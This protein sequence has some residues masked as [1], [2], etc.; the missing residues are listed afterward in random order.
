VSLFTN[1]FLDCA[2]IK[3][4]ILHQIQNQF[5]W[6]E[7]GEDYEEVK[8]EVE[9]KERTKS[10]LEEQKQSLKNFYENIFYQKEIQRSERYASDNQ[11]LRDTLTTTEEENY[12][13]KKRIR[14]LEAKIEDKDHWLDLAFQREGFLVQENKEFKKDK[15][16]LLPN[17]ANKYDTN[18]IYDIIQRIEFHKKI[19]VITGESS[20]SDESEIF[21]F[22]LNKGK[23]KNLIRLLQNIKIP[24]LKGLYFFKIPSWIHPKVINN[25]LSSLNYNLAQLNLNLP[26]SAKEEHSLGLLEEIF[27]ISHKIRERLQ[28]CYFMITEQLFTKIITNFQHCNE[29]KFYKCSIRMKWIEDLK[30][31]EKECNL[32]N[33]LFQRFDDKAVD[34]YG[35]TIKSFDNICKLLAT[36]SKMKNTLKKIQFMDYCPKFYQELVKLDYS[37]F[38]NIMEE[39]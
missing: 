36:N 19:D 2:I 37:G 26:S 15:E 1:N 3:S 21:R 38:G 30:I 32:K 12:T 24:K 39:K 17:L 34:Y 5:K 7:N 14:E 9:F 8:K 16:N 31:E 6:C 29:I 11:E 20:Y 13:L 33:I 35:S 18:S 27:N 28:L 22:N 10:I 25:I 4:Y 23:G